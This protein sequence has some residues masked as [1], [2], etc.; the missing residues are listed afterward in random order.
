MKVFVV[1]PIYP[2]R[3]G[4]AHSN[5]VLCENLSKNH[6]VT[7]ISFSRM[8]PKI[9]YPGKE[10]KEANID[11]SFSV[12]TE[13]ALDSMNP[14]SW[15]SVADRIKKE[16]PDWVVFQW[17][18]TFFTPMYW[19]IA[20]F[21]KN[22]KTRF[23]VVCQNVLPHEESRIHEKLTRL[24]FK[25][26][27][28]FITLSSSDRAILK[29][30]MPSAKSNWITESTYEKQFGKSPSQAQAR[31]K[32]GITGDALLFF[33]FVRP[34]KGLKFLLDAMPQIL[35]AKPDITLMIV[36]E[37][38]NDK[39]EYLDRI[40]RLGLK[41]RLLIVDRY[42]ANDE[43]PAYF[44]AADAV[45]LPYVSSTESGIIQLAYG[46]NTPVITTAVGG[47]VDLIEHGKTGMLCKAEDAADLARVVLEFYEQALRAPI[48]DGMT[49]NADLFRWTPAKEAVFFNQSTNQQ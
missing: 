45:V 33:G 29:Q 44:A 15:L 14:L 48:K 10:Q 12:R 34:Y 30:L 21:G 35:R 24:F 36:G 3:G 39:Q 27:D 8:Y 2:F 17:W 25:K 42:V 11:D 16:R 6:D 9:L 13:Y 22:P 32:L 37:F 20:K 5:R 38:W 7:A 46:L 41:E 18:H 28:Y 23:S 47:N 43:V 40:E 31:K 49:K 19:T 1:G 26:I 4:I